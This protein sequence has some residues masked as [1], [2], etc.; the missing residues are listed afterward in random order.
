MFIFDFF[1][2]MTKTYFPSL[3]LILFRLFWFFHI[4]AHLTFNI[5]I[6]PFFSSFINIIVIVHDILT[7]GNG[8]VTWR[9]HVRDW[10]CCENYCDLS[11]RRAQY[12]IR[13]KKTHSYTQWTCWTNLYFL[14]YF[15]FIVGIT[16]KLVL[17]V[18]VQIRLMIMYI[19][20]LELHT[21]K[22]SYTSTKLRIWNSKVNVCHY[23]SHLSEWRVKNIV[24]IKLIKYDVSCWKW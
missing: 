15:F 24:W 21:E 18:P 8:C 3:L 1:F 10:S 9:K 20:G 2:L 17:L 11:I 19:W 5:R 23:F 6:K 4:N 12:R 14:W 7:Q 13:R 16:N 22:L